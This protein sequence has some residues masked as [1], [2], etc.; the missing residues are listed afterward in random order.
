MHC[1][2]KDYFCPKT[3]TGVLK[4][5]KNTYCIHH[6]AGSWQELTNGQKVKRFITRKILGVCI[7]DKFVQLKRQLKTDKILDNLKIISGR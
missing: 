5:T 6:F 1:F 4:L 2:P 3:S 7:T